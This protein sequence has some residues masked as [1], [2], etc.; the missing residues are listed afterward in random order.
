M[1]YILV[2]AIN[3]CYMQ[4]NS[5]LWAELIISIKNYLKERASKGYILFTSSN[6]FMGK[7]LT[8][9]LIFIYN[10]R[11]LALDPEILSFFFKNII[12]DHDTYK[13][14][15]EQ[16]MVA[17][18]L[19]ELLSEKQTI[20]QSDNECLNSFN[21]VCNLFYTCFSAK[22]GIDME[23]EEFNDS[24]SQEDIGDDKKFTYKNYTIKKNEFT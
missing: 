3:R 14:E 23:E 9:S 22:L 19:M 24:E 2:I 6:Q 8:M 1:G 5:N 13:T 15:V 21:M 18:K 11:Q 12:Q 4:T 17:H 16:L 10:N 20:S 7:I